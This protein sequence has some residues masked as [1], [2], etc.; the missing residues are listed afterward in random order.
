M[1]NKGGKEEGEEG[2]GGDVRMASAVGSPGMERS[3][4]EGGIEGGRESPAV[5]SMVVEQTA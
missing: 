4:S 1:S 2:E 3:E 5:A